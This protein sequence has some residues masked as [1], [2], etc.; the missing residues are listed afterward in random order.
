MIATRP[1]THGSGGRLRPRDGGFALVLALLVVAMAAGAIGLAA[2]ASSRM[3]SAGSSIMSEHTLECGIGGTARAKEALM[4]A[5]RG[6]STID[7]VIATSATNGNIASAN[8]NPGTVSVAFFDND[9]G[10]GDP[11][12]DVDNRSVIRATCGLERASTTIEV[13]GQ[14]TFGSAFSGAAC[15]CSA[16]DFNGT[17]GTDSYDSLDGPYNPITNIGSM[18]TVQSNGDLELAGNVD[19]DVIAQGNVT[20]SGTVTGSVFAGGTVS[21]A[22]IT[23]AGGVFQNMSPALVPCRCNNG[24]DIDQLVT[25]TAAANDNGSMGLC[26]PYRSGTSFNI[27]HGSCVLPGGVYY[28][29][30]FRITGSGSVLVDPLLDPADPAQKVVIVLTG[31]GPFDFGGNGLVNGTNTALNLEIYSNSATD[32]SIHGTADFAGVLY[33]PNAGQ[34]IHG[35]TDI[36]GG[37]FGNVI[38]NGGTSDLHFDENLL[39]RQDFLDSWRRLPGTWRIVNG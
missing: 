7:D 14:G 25:D 39:S 28:F 23:V 20:G 1:L 13:Q 6:G 35:S 16:V 22:N 33:A 21:L 24:I 17:V 18:G 27:T 15:G 9:D 34:I 38:S 31:A 8:L 30:S 11:A 29:T 4:N 32:I 12:T 26:A 37:I 5:F 2:A 36:D 19:G 3:R 10:D